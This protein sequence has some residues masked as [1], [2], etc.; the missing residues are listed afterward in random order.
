MTTRLMAAPREDLFAYEVLKINIRLH[1][2][3]ISSLLLF[4]M[5]VMSDDL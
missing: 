5:M 3:F 1:L 2:H 4:G